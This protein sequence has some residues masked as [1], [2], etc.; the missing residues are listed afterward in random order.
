[1]SDAIL[2]I[3]AGSSSIEFSL[4]DES[5]PTGPERPESPGRRRRQRPLQGGLHG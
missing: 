5:G 2:V 4:F 1:M 3:N